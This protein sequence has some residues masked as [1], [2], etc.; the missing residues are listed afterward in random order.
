MM[1]TF[2]F[3]ILALLNTYAED[4][5]ATES[6][7]EPALEAVN[8]VASPDDMMLIWPKIPPSGDPKEVKKAIES[9]R[10]LDKIKHGAVALNTKQVTNITKKLEAKNSD[11]RVHII[12][13]KPLAQALTKISGKRPSAS[14]FN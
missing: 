12:A 7:M 2:I 6:Q 8:E 14:D 10:L 5:T 1:R 3:L 13:G 4:E 11:S 9:Q